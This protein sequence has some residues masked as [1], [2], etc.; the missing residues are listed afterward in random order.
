MARSVESAGLL[1][2]RRRDGAPQ[3]LLAH[4][5]GPFW[6]GRDA[7]A[8]MIPKGAIEPGED[9]L[10]A[11]LRE[12]AE[13][14]GFSVEGPFTALAPIRQH[15]GKRVRCWLAE[16]DLDLAH[17]ASNTFELEWPPRSGR[18]ASFPE[19]DRAAW[20]DPDEAMARIL[21]SQAPLLVEAMERITT[22]RL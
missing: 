7:G 14:T 11:A 19:V 2:W 17:L 10:A 3:F 1:V 22:D 8:W 5:G 4:P 9:A 16:A 18:M 15:G 13:E 12:F 21:P 20:F 6:R